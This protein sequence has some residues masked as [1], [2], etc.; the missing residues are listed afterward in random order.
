VILAINL[1]TASFILL[2]FLF[3]QLTCDLDASLISKKPLLSYGAV[4]QFSLHT[5]KQGI[6]SYRNLCV[7][8][9]QLF[10]TTFFGILLFDPN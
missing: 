7:F 6:Y 9:I 5:V 2:Y 4:R 8:F 10:C 3:L 1:K